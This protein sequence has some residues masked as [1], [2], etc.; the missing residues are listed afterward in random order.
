MNITVI[1]LGKLKEKYLRDAIDEY[2]K[3]ISAYGRLDIIE[4]GDC[5]IVQA[6]A[7]RVARVC[8]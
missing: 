8:R 3:R 7:V 1:A 4:E 2:A 6:C 5:K